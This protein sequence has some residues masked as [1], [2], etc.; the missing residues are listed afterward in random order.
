MPE[1]D[2]DFC[3]YKIHKKYMFHGHKTVINSLT[4]DILFSIINKL[5]N[6]SAR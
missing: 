1:R 6:R 3:T 5:L 2:Q 4:K